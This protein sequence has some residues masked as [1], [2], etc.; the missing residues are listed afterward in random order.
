[1]ETGC[2]FA[3]YGFLKSTACVDFVSRN[4]GES[5][6]RHRGLHVMRS[7][8]QTAGSMRVVSAGRVIVLNGTADAIGR[9]VTIRRRGNSGSAVNLLILRGSRVNPGEFRQKF[10]GVLHFVPIFQSSAAETA[11][12]FFVGGPVFLE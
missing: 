1:M 2:D 6:T 3:E 10:P 12:A 8:G 11:A 5:G 4:Q 9:G 7:W